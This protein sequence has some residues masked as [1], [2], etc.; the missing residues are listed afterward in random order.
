MDLVGEIGLACGAVTHHPELEDRELEGFNAAAHKLEMLVRELQSEISGMRLVPIATVFQAMK[1]VSRDTARRTGKQVELIISGETT[2]ID[3]VMVDALHDPLVHL[4][5]NAIDHGLELPEERVASGK[6]A[7]GR[8]MLDASHQGGEVLIKVKD[9]GR[10]IHRKRVLARAKSRGLV[11]E[12][13][14]LSDQQTL[15][16][17]FAPGFSTKDNID[18][19]SGRGVGM[20]LIKTAIESQRGRVRLRSVEGQGSS[21]EMTLPLTLA[22]LDAMVVREGG[23]LYAVPIEKVREVFTA[24]EDNVCQASAEGKTMLRVRDELVPMLRLGEYYG[25][26]PFSTNLETGSVVMVVQTP[27]GQ[28]AIPVDSLL[29]NQPVM[30]KPL[31]GVISHVRAAAGCG[32]LR[33]GDVALTLDCDQLNV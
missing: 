16:L 18:E 12:S 4:I 8:V 24:H 10:G 14:T 23:Q 27:R 28:L 5:R 2:E 29:G 1:R 31:K 7:T 22:F 25:N 6:P 11:A 17:I 30:L 9:D 32:M 33:T 26:K 19:V 3:K 21:V 15:D 20:D 13:A